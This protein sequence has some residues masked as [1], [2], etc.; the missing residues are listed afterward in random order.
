MKGS[1][2]FVRLGGTL[3]VVFAGI[4][5]VVLFLLW[6]RVEAAQ[7]FDWRIFALLL[8]IPIMVCF[9]LAGI[10]AMWERWD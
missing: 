9:A 2:I 10:C 4:A 6:L 1:E 3:C 8:G 7:A 5:A